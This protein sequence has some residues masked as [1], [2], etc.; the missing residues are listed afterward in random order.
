[1][2]GLTPETDETGW[3]CTRDCI[4]LK[5]WCQNGDIFELI[6]ASISV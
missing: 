3:C 1:M 6:A 5:E 4:R 2:R